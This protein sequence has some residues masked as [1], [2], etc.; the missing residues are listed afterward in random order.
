MEN[1]TSIYKTLNQ[2]LANEKNYTS[3]LEKLSQWIYRRYRIK[4]AFCE[5]YGNRWSHVCGD[6]SLL[7]PQQKIRLGNNLGIL[8][9]PAGKIASLPVDVV[10]ALRRASEQLNKKE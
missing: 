5:I 6:K 7:L 4:N 3:K 2:L 8:L 9:E 1:G 10:E